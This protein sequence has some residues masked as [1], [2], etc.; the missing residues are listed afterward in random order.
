[1]NPTV[2]GGELRENF[3]NLL[4]TQFPVNPEQGAFQHLWDDFFAH[5]GKIMKG[6][7]LQL[8][9]PF[10]KSE[11]DAELV[12]FAPAMAKLPYQP[13]LHQTRAF[14]R[15][16]APH[17]KPTLVATGTGS[18]K[19]ECFTWPILSYCAQFK[20]TPGVRAIIIYPMNALAT[21]QARRLAETIDKNPGLHGV[22]VGLYIG[23]DAPKFVKRD[24]EMGP[25][26]VI[27]DRETILQTPPQILLTNYKMLDY[28]L[29]RPREKKLWQHNQ[30]DTLKYLV[31]DELHTFDGA[32]AADLACLVRRLKLRLNMPD[33]K[34]CCVGT[35]ATLGTG[36]EAV[37][38]ICRYA[39]KIFSREFGD[40]AI[41]PESRLT[42][43]ELCAENQDPI[44]HDVYVEAVFKALDGGAKTLQET[45]DIL[46]KRSKDGLLGDGVLTD[47]EACEKIL[48]MCQT[49]SVL[50]AQK[51]R[52]YPEVK[53]QYWLRE[54]ARMVASVPRDPQKHRPHLEFS[55]DLTDPMKLVDTAGRDNRYVDTAD[56]AK[57]PVR[58]FPVGNC[59]KCGSMAWA[60]LLSRDQTEVEG[61]RTE[62]YRFA[63]DDNLRDSLVYLHPLT[64]TEGMPKFAH[65]KVRYLCP[66]CLKLHAER[67]EKCA[68]C[69]SATVRVLMERAEQVGKKSGRYVHTCPY[70]GGNHGNILFIGM[71]TATMLSTCISSITTSKANEDKKIIAFSDN[72]QDTSHRAGFFG[73]RTWAAT[74]RG[75]LAHYFAEVLHGQATGYADF[76]KGFWAYVMSRHGG[77]TREILGEMMPQDLKWLNDWIKLTGPKCEAPGEHTMR[78]LEARVKWEMALEFGC[79][80]GTGRTL[81]NVG[82]CELVPDVPEA[83]DGVWSEL[84]E[85]VCNKTGPL[86]AFHGNPWKMRECVVELMKLMIGHGAFDDGGAVVVAG[87]LTRGGLALRRFPI[88]GVEGVLRSMD[89]QSSHVSVPGIKLGRRTLSTS[90]TMGLE[91]EDV[92]SAELEKSVPGVCLDEPSFVALFEALAERGFVKDFVREGWSRYW[93]VENVRLKVV[94][95][96]NADAQ[97]PFRRQYLEGDV[98]RLNPAE[99]TGLLSRDEREGLEAAFKS[100]ERHTWNPNLISATPT[101]E[102][103]V[104]IG[105]LSSV[106]LCSVPPTQSQFIQRMGRSGRANGSALNMTIANAKAHDLYFYDEPREMIQG[107]VTSPGVFLDA[108]AILSRQY[109]GF[110]LSKWMLADDKNAFPLDVGK[111]LAALKRSPDAAFPRNYFAWYG[112]NQHKLYAEFYQCVSG[113]VKSP[114]TMEVLSRFAT[115][116]AKDKEGLIGRFEEEVF[117]AKQAI[118]SY[119]AK[120]DALK[121][122]RKQVEKDPSLTAEV[123]EQMLEDLEIEAKAYQYLVLDLRGKKFI[124]WLCDSAELLPNY[125]FPE[126]GVHLQSILWRREIRTE[127]PK[128]QKLEISRP[129]SS[130][131]TELVPGAVFFGH[132]HHVCVD[133]LDLQQ[134]QRSELEN[135]RWRFCPNCDHIERERADLSATCPNCGANWTDVGQK[136]D[137]LPARQF[138]TVKAS[139]DTINDDSTDDRKPKFYDCKKFFERNANGSVI[140]SFVCDN[141]E[142][143]FGFEYVSHLI[144]R[145]VNFGRFGAR[146]E[147]E[148][149]VEVNGEAVGGTGFAICPDCGKALPRTDLGAD[150]GVEHLRNCVRNQME[151]AERKPDLKVGFYREYE[152][153]ALRIYVPSLGADGDVQLT[154]FMAALQLGLKEHFRGQ[155]DHLAMEVQSL[156]DKANGVRNQYVVLYDGVPGGTGYLKQFVSDKDRQTLL[157]EV[158]EK[159]LAK[160]KGCSCG[161]NPEKDGCYHCLYRYRN[162]GGRQNVSRRAAITLLTDLVKLKDTVKPAADGQIVSGGAY[163]NALESELEKRFDLRLKAFVDS[164]GQKGEWREVF[165]AD[166]SPGL[167]IRIPGDPKLGGTETDKIWEVVP[168]KCFG[169]EDGVLVMSKP[170]FVFYPQDDESKVKAKPVAVFTDG[171]KYHQAI[172]DEDILKRMALMRAGYRVWSLTWNDVLKPTA[173]NPAPEIP[174]WRQHVI[175]HAH[176]S[177]LGLQFFNGNS[178]RGNFWN[179]GYN[180]PEQEIDRLFAYLQV[181]DDALFVAHAKFEAML[182]MAPPTLEQQPLSVPAPCAGMIQGTVVGDVSCDGFGARIV[183]RQDPAAFM[184]VSVGAVAEL[185][186]LTVPGQETWQRFLG[187]ATY[188]QFF[189]AAALFYTLKSKENGFWQLSVLTDPEAGSTPDDWGRAF[190]DAEG[191]ALS[192]ALLQ[193]FK[194]AGFPPPVCFS[195]IEGPGGAILASPW[196]KWEAE[197][198]CVLND[199]L[200]QLHGWKVVQA[201]ESAKVEQIVS[202]VKEAF[203]HG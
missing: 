79:K 126:P 183:M 166:F 201:P 82:V 85:A 128:Y 57:E 133:Q 186:D 42:Y 29:I 110:T 97:N 196:F 135:C 127:P 38:D 58:Y 28:M 203:N 179:E 138:I 69:G 27:T 104:D 184:H 20:N 11:D 194:D 139:A 134:Y 173:E 155:V 125:A 98:H 59:N 22:N 171:W 14:D 6:P 5:E 16:S 123:R 181:G 142:I 109:F 84:A 96:A 137:I 121:H 140:K 53:V 47:A 152:T 44:F 195:D 18:G 25:D 54:L 143:P 4:R 112:K 111:M 95:V 169:P 66:K 13:Y 32:Q 12:R 198:V 147:G 8:P 92:L 132:G 61:T 151:G 202:A 2:V 77:D 49:L 35:S 136:F 45:V 160:L 122:Q 146:R 19:T 101:L 62:I 178:A 108:A 158:M 102:M 150:G 94:P 68:G 145:E 21:D 65:G 168:Q 39:E 114:D 156:P 116:G 75:H 73:G 99:H 9:L 199:E 93:L 24:Q 40:D 197:K 176:R 76:V 105:D 37:A 148:A 60:A 187:F 100:K 131:L 1:M 90:I 191:D 70:C 115:T 164:F 192:A 129:A 48:A 107:T 118:N 56:A 67:A 162:P 117:N 55:D 64:E 172:V 113:A 163:T 165:T 193:A 91:R 30:P 36:P 46:C 189:D 180:K 153:E 7:Y 159:A 157:F 124:E 177:D 3:E 15:I 174:A 200:A 26:H 170:D 83:D 190:A 103:G 154:S 88:Q 106:L 23:D 119:A 80:A 149:G 10:K 86:M 31:V 188:F 41:I 185:N 175:N 50:R 161:S 144:L 167:R 33:N 87:V 51:G 43:E 130:G 78:M 81:K 74:F 120:R 182:L 52:G 17:F 71:R 89:R 63:F 34:L 141:D 72:V